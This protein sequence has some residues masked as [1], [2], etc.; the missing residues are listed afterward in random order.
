M[1]LAKRQFEDETG[2]WV[3]GRYA[4]EKERGT[5]RGHLVD[6][7]LQ[8]QPKATT[9]GEVLP[10]VASTA[11]KRQKNQSFKTRRLSIVR[12][13]SRICIAGFASENR[14][15]ILQ[16]YNRFTNI[17]SVFRQDIN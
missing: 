3:S 13:L 7:V 2:W 1:F 4:T 8:S 9:D 6:V 12:G 17:Q 16:K 11:A 5:N 10:K 15:M 14:N